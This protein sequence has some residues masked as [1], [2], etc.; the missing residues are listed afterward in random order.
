MPPVSRAALQVKPKSLRLIFVTA[1]IATRVLPQGP[2]VGGVGPSTAKMDLAG[3]ATDGQLAFDRPLSVPG[4]TDAFGLET[5][6]RKLL[7]IKKISALE[8][9]IALVI[10]GVNGGS[11]DGDLHARVRQIR[12]VQKQRA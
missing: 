2:F 11:F 5:Q 1:E 4:D 9:G 6:G 8:V 10:A 3:N 7:H 12:F